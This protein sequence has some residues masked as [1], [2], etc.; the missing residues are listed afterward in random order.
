MIQALLSV[1]LPGWSLCTSNDNL[2]A[3]ALFSGKIVKLCR[4]KIMNKSLELGLFSGRLRRLFRWM[5][6]INKR[7]QMLTSCAPSVHLTFIYQKSRSTRRQQLSLGGQSGLLDAAAAA[8][9]IKQCDLVYF[10]HNS[11]YLTTWSSS[12]TL[13]LC[14]VA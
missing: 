13:S 14:V 7:K 6:E 8:V 11:C 9:T 4:R 2:K 12:F 5:V 3:T 10:G 1:Y